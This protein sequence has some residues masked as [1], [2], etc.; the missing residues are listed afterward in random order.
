MTP[1][2]RP[3]VKG[4]VQLAGVRDPMG[5]L[6]V[7][8]SRLPEAAGKQYGGWFTWALQFLVSGVPERRGPPNAGE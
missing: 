5:L 7:S 4:G 8:R 1:V 3:Q 6:G 2:G